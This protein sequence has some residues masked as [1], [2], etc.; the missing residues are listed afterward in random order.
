MN[1][2]NRCWAKENGGTLRAKIYSTEDGVFELPVPAT[3]AFSATEERESR[4]FLFFCF[5]SP[6]EAGMGKKLLLKKYLRR[7]E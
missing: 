3:L 2:S 6:H 7:Q 4:S 5:S 1:K